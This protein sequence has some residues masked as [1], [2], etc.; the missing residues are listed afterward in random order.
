MDITWILGAVIVLLAAVDW[1]ENRTPTSTTTPVQNAN[2]TTSSTAS[3]ANTV[4]QLANTVASAI[5][6]AASNAS[7]A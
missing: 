6:S 2:G 3:L 4:S 7:S 5:K 1:A